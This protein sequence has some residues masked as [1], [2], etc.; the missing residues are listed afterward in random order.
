MD[1]GLGIEWRIRD[2]RNQGLGMEKS[3]DGMENT[4]GDREDYGMEIERTLE[5]ERTIRTGDRED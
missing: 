4:R 5:I 2:R 1:K 3:R